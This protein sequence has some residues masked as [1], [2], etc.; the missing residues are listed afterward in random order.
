MHV[1]NLL[2]QPLWL[3][4][5]TIPL[6]FAL[7]LG[8]GIVRLVS[9]SVAWCMLIHGAI[10]SARGWF[11]YSATYQKLHVIAERSP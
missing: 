11:L 3:V 9:G 5:L 7:G 1:I 6:A 10:D 4:S 8:L 2:H